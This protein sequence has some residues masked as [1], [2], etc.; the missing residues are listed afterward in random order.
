MFATARLTSWIFH[1]RNF[2][3]AANVYAGGYGQLE[4]SLQLFWR[5]IGSLTRY[6]RSFSEKQNRN[7]HRHLA[8]TLPFREIKSTRHWRQQNPNPSHTEG[9]GTPRVSSVLEEDSGA[10]RNS[11]PPA[12]PLCSLLRGFA[13][14]KS[15]GR[16]KMPG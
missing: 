3:L 5:C 8:P 15:D 7:L 2:L 14:I 11:W 13:K 10:A 4:R 16:G 6:I 1:C 12:H 9:S